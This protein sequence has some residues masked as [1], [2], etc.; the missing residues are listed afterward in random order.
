[1]GLVSSGHDAPVA[2]PQK[3]V[4]HITTEFG[5]GSGKPSVCARFNAAERAMESNYWNEIMRPFLS[6]IRD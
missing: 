5:A 1:M 3:R 4:R 2:L 6:I